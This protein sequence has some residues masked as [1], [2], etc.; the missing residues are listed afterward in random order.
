[1]SLLSYTDLL[2]LV[3]RDVITGVDPE[4]INA[5]SI[6]ICLGDELLIEDVDAG[7]PVDLS[8]KESPLMRP[9]PLSSGGY[10]HLWPQQFALAASRELFH[11]PDDIAAE[12]R[13]KSSG[14]RAGLDAALAMWCD[15]G[16]NGSALTLELRNNL[17]GHPLLLRPGLKI[18]QMIFYR[19][20]PVP[21]HASYAQRG[22]Y[23]GDR[24]V[25]PSK[26]VR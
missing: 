22:Q 24:G 16:W 2:D 5:A 4:H 19:T 18:G 25:Q 14:A 13:L 26:G 10:W 21:S 8:A 20:Q 12:F 17:G 1:M 23:N 7:K 15:P 6:D 9:L 11:L 3:Q